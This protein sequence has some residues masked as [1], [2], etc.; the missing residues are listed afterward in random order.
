MSAEQLYQVIKHVLVDRML[1]LQG[2][3]NDLYCGQKAKLSR[4][5]SFFEK[6]CLVKPVKHYVCKFNKSV[7]LGLSEV[8]LLI[9][10]VNS[11]K[12]ILHECLLTEE[13]FEVLFNEVVQSIVCLITQG[14]H[15]LEI[16]SLHVGH[17]KPRLIDRH[18]HVFLKELR[19]FRFPADI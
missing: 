19:K 11:R 10:I 5:I 14:L 17:V 12:E 1:L 16:N 4:L 6:L 2:A 8:L 15:K 13:R 9:R 18:E 3:V 7:A